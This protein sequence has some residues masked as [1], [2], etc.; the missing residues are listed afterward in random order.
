MIACKLLY[1]TQDDISNG[2]GQKK[3]TELLHPVQPKGWNHQL[4]I[5]R[6]KYH[7]LCLMAFLDKTWDCN[8]VS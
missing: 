7:I 4:L 5:K 1:L 6:R 8:G 3:I 2:G